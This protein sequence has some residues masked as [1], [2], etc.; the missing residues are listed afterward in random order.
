[1]KSNLKKSISLLLATMMTVSATASVFSGSNLNLVSEYTMLENLTNDEEDIISLVEPRSFKVQLPISSEVDASTVKWE[2][3]RNDSIQYG[4]PEYY[5]AQWQGGEIDSIYCYKGSENPFIENVKTVVETIDGANYLTLTFNTVNYFNGDYSVPHENGGKYIDICGYF[6]LVASIGGTTLGSTILKI[7]PNDQFKTM[8][9]IYIELG[10]MED[11]A[12]DMNNLYVEK[13]S[14]GE[15]TSGFDMPYLIIAD[16]KNSVDNW[17]DYVDFATTSPTEAL[18]AINSGKYNDIKIPLMYGNI[19]ANETSGVDGMIS[20]MWKIL[21]TAKSDNKVLTYKTL[22]GFTPEGEAQ[23]KI[24]MENNNIAIPDLVAEEATYLGYIYADNFN[25]EN[26]VHFS[27]VVDIDK[28]YTTETIE[29]DVEELLENVFFVMVPEQNVE[30]RTFLTRTASNGF[31]LNRDNSFQI[32]SE[33]Q[34]MQHLIGKFNPILFSEY[35][36]RVRNFQCEPCDPPHEPNFEYDLLAEGLMA[37][38]ESFGINAVA[39]NNGYNSYV[40]PQRDYLTANEDGTT[41]WEDPWDDMSTSYTPQ[42]AMLHG[43]LGYTVELPA[44]SDETADA[45]IYGTLGQA[46]FVGEGKLTYLTNQVKIWE[47]GVTNANS[48]AYELVGQW[49]TDQNDIE[50]AESDLFRPVYNGEGENGNFYPE[51]Y[52]IPM[53]GEN[54][55]NLANAYEMMEWLSRNDVKIKLTEESITVDGVTYPKGTMIV[56]MYQAKRSVANGALYDGTLINNW[57]VLYSEGI[58]TFNETRGFDMVT[59][60]KPAEFEIIDDACSDFMNYEQSLSYLSTLT[61]SFTGVT[62][63][64]VVISNVSEN[65]TSA[66]NALLKNGKKVGMVSDENSPYYGDFVCDYKDWLTVKDTYVLTGHGVGSNTPS[67]N[68]IYYSP[69][70]YISGQP[71]VNLDGGYIKTTFNASSYQWNYDRWAMEMMNFDLTADPTQADIIVGSANLDEKALSEVKAGK[72]YI[73]YGVYATTGYAEL[74]DESM[75]VHS[76]AE[77]MDCLSYVTYPETNLINAS[78]VLDEDDVLYGYG[79]GYFSKVPEGATILAQLD[80]TKTPTEGFIKAITDE[81]KEK[82]NLYLNNSYQG[83]SYTGADKDG[84]NIDVALFASSLTHKVHQQDEFAFISN[85][86]FSKT[87]S[88]TKY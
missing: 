3:K 31:D 78:Y 56:S 72:S 85:F 27:G 26:G 87:M 46:D 30:G 71:S 67:A 18:E 86:A 39:N 47:R 22:T 9:D 80:G 21:E 44:Y 33:T 17:L 73:G 84:N 52:I 68:V 4:N 54:Q 16:E 1:M 14:M 20:F 24:D 49:Y 60:A 83:F 29:V 41:Y 63:G 59:V 38:G 69:T 79:L 15:S 51:C 65:S 55:K 81:Q 11:Y 48:N 10:Q 53:D 25:P 42:F 28:Y 19:H 82:M 64:D 74:F 7:S 13:F 70:I 8:N 5:P 2:F 50:G 62:S 35:H 88:D 23:L 43:S 6:D 12:K 58:T 32:T 61:S 77:G 75:M 45:V 66:V 57:T 37:V 34:N 40:I 36:G 76:R